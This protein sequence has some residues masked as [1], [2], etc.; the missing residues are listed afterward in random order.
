[1][2][3][4]DSHMLQMSSLVSVCGRLPASLPAG[5]LGDGKEGYL[6]TEDEFLGSGTGRTQA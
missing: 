6:Q 5:Y 4:R 2:G 3:V 1:M